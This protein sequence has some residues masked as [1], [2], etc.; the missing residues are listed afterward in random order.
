MAVLENMLL[1][2]A[3][4]KEYNSQLLKGFFIQNSVLAYS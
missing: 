4:Y 2:D 3:L 1:E